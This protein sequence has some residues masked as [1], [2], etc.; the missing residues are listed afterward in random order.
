MK[1]VPMNESEGGYQHLT[2]FDRHGQNWGDGIAD[3]NLEELANNIRLQLK[4][5]QN[6]ALGRKFGAI[7]NGGGGNGGSNAS[8]NF[9]NPQVSISGGGSTGTNKTIEQNYYW[10]VYNSQDAAAYGFSLYVTKY[11]QVKFKEYSSVIYRIKGKD[12]KNYYSFT[13]PVK[14]DDDKLSE[15]KSPSA[16]E[17]IKIRKLLPD[18][19]SDDAYI[20]NHTFN[21]EPFGNNFSPYDFRVDGTRGLTLY[22]LNSAGNLK[23]YKKMNDKEPHIAQGFKSNPNNIVFTKEFNDGKNQDVSFKNYYDVIKE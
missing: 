13:I 22:L 1:A 4:M 12:G 3:A 11:L 20:H 23:I 6:R 16:E 10:P 14:F 15:H 8:T 17:I 5:I 18:G 21:N 9:H 2:G 7:M 19:A